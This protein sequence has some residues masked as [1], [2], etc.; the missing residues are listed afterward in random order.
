MGWFGWGTVV[1]QSMLAILLGSMM[2]DFYG[3]PTDHRK[4]D[5]IE[6][7]NEY[8]IKEYALIQKKQSNLSYIQR[9]EVER[10][11]KHRKLGEL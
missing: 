2:D 10:K 6:I 4:A 5:S 11:Y 1:N 9:C 7:E 3:R 8:L